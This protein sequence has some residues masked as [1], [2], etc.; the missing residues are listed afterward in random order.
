MAD[1]PVAVSVKLPM[2]MAEWLRLRAE[3][4]RRPISSLIRLMLEDGIRADAGVP[5]GITDLRGGERG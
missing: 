4:D 1:L 2:W 3:R 5:Q